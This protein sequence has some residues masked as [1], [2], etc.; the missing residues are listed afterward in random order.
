[1]YSFRT[2]EHVYKNHNSKV[3]FVTLT[4]FCYFYFYSFLSRESSWSH[5]VQKHIYKDGNGMVELS[6]YVMK[7]MSF[8]LLNPK[9]FEGCDLAQNIEWSHELSLI[10]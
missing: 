6:L 8:F 1:M 3:S 5:N 2:Q 4:P 9:F 10:D 7:F